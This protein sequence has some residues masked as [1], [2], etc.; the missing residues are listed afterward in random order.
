V[1]LRAIGGLAYTDHGSGADGRE[2][3]LKMLFRGLYGGTDMEGG[4]VDSLRLVI[5]LPEL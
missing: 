1:I 3:V 4:T 5:A 2:N